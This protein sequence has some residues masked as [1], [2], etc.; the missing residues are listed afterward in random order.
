MEMND[1][2]NLHK[3]RFLKRKGMRSIENSTFRQNCFKC[4]FPTCNY[5]I[6]YLYEWKKHMKSHFKSN[7]FQ[8][9]KCNKRYNSLQIIKNHIIRHI[10]NRIYN[11][12]DKSCSMS[13]IS[14]SQLKIHYKTKHFNRR[15]KNNDFEQEFKKEMFQC[16]DEI[17]KKKVLY[18][19]EYKKFMKNYPIINTMNL[20]K[21]ASIDE[22]GLKNIL[23][24]L[25]E[26][27]FES[28]ETSDEYLSKK[29]K[30]IL[31]LLKFIKER[32]D[33]D[34]DDLNGIYM[35]INNLD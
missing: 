2:L 4:T 15:S 9:S 17:Q 8:C 18:D 34:N 12:F 28:L 30:I 29:E 13:F 24:E 1:H 6:K 16:K 19:E 27:R 22:I 32:L 11:C 5:K 21:N 3:K 7:N 31:V 23:S 14:H 26:R 25:K 20:N 10:K 33:N 35:Y